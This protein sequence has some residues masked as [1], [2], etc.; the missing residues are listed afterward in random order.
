M[1][2]LTHHKKLYAVQKNMIEKDCIEKIEI[3]L[4]GITKIIPHEFD[5]NC[6]IFSENMRY[7][8]FA[9]RKVKK[10]TTGKD[11]MGGWYYIN[12]TIERLHR[13]NKMIVTSKEFIEHLEEKNELVFNRKLF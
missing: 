8:Q 1:I 7:S 10:F 11:F 9:D 6:Y 12:E 13:K 5:T 2:G 3:F 4:K